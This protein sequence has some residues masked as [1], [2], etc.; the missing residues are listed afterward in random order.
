MGDP[1]SGILRKLG[2]DE[3]FY[4][5]TA[6]GNYTG[7]SAY[8]LEDFLQK[9][10]KIEAKSLEFHL[11]RE[12]FEKWVSS[13]LGDVQ[14]AKE[15]ALLRRQKAAGVALRDRLSTIVTKRLKELERSA[16]EPGPEKR[17]IKKGSLWYERGNGEG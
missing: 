1:S 14:L 5:C 11:F 10:K 16:F 2:N 9:I 17:V 7:Q 6:L 4:F 3:A 8:S 15:I 12:D 13:T